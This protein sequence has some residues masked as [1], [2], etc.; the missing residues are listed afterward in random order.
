MSREVSIPVPTAANVTSGQLD[1]ATIDPRSV[2]GRLSKTLT[3]DD[4]L[5]VY[6]SQ[7]PSSTSES[8]NLTYV[9]NVIGTD[10]DATQPPHFSGWRFLFMKRL[11]ASA[12]MNPGLFFASGDGVSVAAIDPISVALH[13][14][15][16]FV[17]VSLTAF[18]APVRLTL[19]ST[20]ST[21]DVFNVYATD[22]TTSDDL[23]GTT[24]LGA[25]QGGGSR[26][27]IGSETTLLASTLVVSSTNLVIQRTPRAV[28]VTST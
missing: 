20:M 26:L 25:L 9:A 13:A 17:R 12:T 14:N 10:G 8:V 22:D 28:S 4:A 21:N 11:S 7:D 16:A 1:L 19:A 18:N 5:A 24:F 2:T 6:G 15:D 3:Q 23:H 27:P